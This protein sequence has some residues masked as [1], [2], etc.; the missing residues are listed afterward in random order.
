MDYEIEFLRTDYG[1]HE[2]SEQ[3]AKVRKLFED[4]FSELVKKATNE[5]EVLELFRKFL[6]ECA[7]REYRV[8][9]CNLVMREHF[10]KDGHYRFIKESRLEAK[11]PTAY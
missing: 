8:I 2:R 6:S 3:H 11:G 7:M 9:Y 4:E 5:Q 10:P 1:R